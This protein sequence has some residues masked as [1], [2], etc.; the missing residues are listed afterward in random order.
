MFREES[1]GSALVVAVVRTLGTAHTE[2]TGCN[3]DSAAWEEV[4]FADSDR[5]A[6]R[7]NFVGAEVGSGNRARA[8]VALVVD[9]DDV[10]AVTIAAVEIESAPF[11]VHWADLVGPAL[12][13]RRGAGLLHPVAA[14]EEKIE[15][16]QEAVAA[17]VAAAELVHVPRVE[18]LLLRRVLL[19]VKVGLDPKE[20]E[21][22]T[23]AIVVLVP[24]LWPAENQEIQIRLQ[25]FDSLMANS[26]V[27][28]HCEVYQLL[29]LPMEVDPLL[30]VP[31]VNA[32]SNSDSGELR[33]Q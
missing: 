22:P 33:Q 3:I 31:T 18:D 14:K 21:Y 1:I 6:A 20:D 24:V 9:D 2:N 11:L 5:T 16:E 7:R 27:G 17:V 28:G 10:A 4:L 25:T 29:H 32:P 8:S 12:F 19:F 13:Y 30:D 23:V 26:L 15:S